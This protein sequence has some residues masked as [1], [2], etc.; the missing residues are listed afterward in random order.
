M[1]AG[2]KTSDAN[3]C[4]IAC[5]SR[6][7]SESPGS[8]G[9]NVLMGVLQGWGGLESLLEFEGRKRARRALGGVVKQHRVGQGGIEELPNT[10]DLVVAE[11]E[12]LDVALIIALAV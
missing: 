8:L 7:V 5:I 3:L 2:R 1:P 4:A 12:H 6:S 10:A 11:F 9:G